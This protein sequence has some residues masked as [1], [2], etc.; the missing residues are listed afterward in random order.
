MKT[1][2]FILLVSVCNTL[3]GQLNTDSIESIMIRLIRKD[4]DL[5][6]AQYLY[7]SEKCKKTSE[8]HL[9]YALKYF[10][11]ETFSHDETIPFYNK[12]VLTKPSDRYALFNKDSILVSFGG[13][14]LKNDAKWQYVTEIMTATYISD[15]SVSNINQIVAM[16]L[17]NNFKSS[18]AHYYS[19]IKN[20]S[21]GQIYRGYISVGFKKEMYYGQEY[22]TFYCVGVFDK[23]IYLETNLNQYMKSKN[24]DFYLD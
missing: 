14:Y 16:E 19:M 2:S 8:I 22:T 21:G 5:K 17:F 6:G 3:F 20:V 7:T 12:K 23:S 1:L 11:N 4:R 24:S 18:H 9:S 10:I 15:T 13:D